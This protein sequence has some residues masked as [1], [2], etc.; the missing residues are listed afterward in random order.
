MLRHRGICGGILF[1]QIPFH[2]LRERAAEHIMNLANSR[3]RYGPGFIGILLHTDHW[4]R[5]RGQE[6]LIVSLQC[7]GRDFGKFQFPEIWLDVVIDQPGIAGVYGRRPF[8]FSIKGNVFFHQFRNRRAVR[9][10]E[11]ANL[12]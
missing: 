4:N 10:N 12:L 7:M 8:C 6:L 1:N 5:R 3:S 2:G 11:I 9:N